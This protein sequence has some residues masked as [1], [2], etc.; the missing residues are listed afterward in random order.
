V[1]HRTIELMSPRLLLLAFV[2]V[3]QAIPGSAAPAVPDGQHDFDFQFGTWSVHV[4]RLLH[5]LSGSTSWAQYDGTHVV[6]K[7]WGG[8]ANLGVL[9]IDGPS[10]HVEGQSLRLYNP[11]THQWSFTFAQSGE[12][13]MGPPMIGEFKGGHGEFFN[14]ETYDGRAVL[15]RNITS[16]ITPTTYRD[17]YAYSADGGKTWETNWIATFTLANGKT[18]PVPAFDSSDPQQ[19]AFDFEWGTWRAHLRRLLHPLTGSR[20]WVSYEGPSVVRKVWNGRANL[21]EIDLAGSAG[22]IVGLSLRLYN[23]QA[24]QWNISFSA[25][26]NGILGTPPTVGAFV[27]GRGEFYDRETLANGRAIYVRFV[28]SNISR[29]HFHFEQSFS[30]NGGQRWESNWIADFTRP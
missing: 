19:H 9:E 27:N 21:G 23:R 22:R 7:V 15:V 24:R 10:G 25:L 13:T 6:S 28:F 3:L 17:E 12:G 11:Q 29:S 8:R 16:D 5:P 18:Q 30:D 20:N 4:K 14:Q 26:G 1:A 2:F